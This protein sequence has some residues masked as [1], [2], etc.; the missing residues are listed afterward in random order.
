MGEMRLTPEQIHD[1]LVGNSQALVDLLN[2]QTQEKQALL[3]RVAELEV[4]V[5]LPV[6]EEPSQHVGVH[7][8]RH[9][10]NPLEATMSHWWAEKQE[11]GH[12]LSYLLGTG[13]QQAFVTLRDATVAA[14][15]IQWLA[16][17]AGQNFLCDVH[18]LTQ[19]QFLKELIID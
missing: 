7:A 17:D 19:G 18:R 4:M 10:N 9:R 14:T 5:G 8:S 11:R 12:L 15:L 6:S 13:N 3:A 2:Q 16:S 1:Q